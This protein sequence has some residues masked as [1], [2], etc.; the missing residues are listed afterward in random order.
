MRDR[1][2]DKCHDLACYVYPDSA[3][4]ISTLAILEPHILVP[5]NLLQ[6]NTPHSTER[7]R[8]LELNVYFGL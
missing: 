1:K 6:V 8:H 7:R 2:P 4:I 3:Q 5:T